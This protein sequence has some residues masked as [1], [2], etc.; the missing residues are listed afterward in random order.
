MEGLFLF[1]F[2]RVL[3]DFLFRNKTT[4]LFL[5]SHIFG[6][7]PLPIRLRSLVRLFRASS[8]W[9]FNVVC[10]QIVKR[11]SSTILT[12]RLEMLLQFWTPCTWLASTKIPT[13]M[14]SSNVS[15]KHTKFLTMPKNVDN[16]ILLIPTSLNSRKIYRILTISRYGWLLSNGLLIFFI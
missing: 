7:K 10:F 16:L 12:K 5:V 3:L 4:T 8:L 14:P 6:T 15:R 2:I 1:Y 11:C 13:T 9:F